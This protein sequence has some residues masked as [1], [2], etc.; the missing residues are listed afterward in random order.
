MNY[1]EMLKVVKEISIAA[2]ELILGVY[3]S[4][5]FEIQIKSDNSPVTKADQIANDYIVSELQKRYPEVGVLAEESQKDDVRLT[6]SHVWIIDPLDGTKEFIKRNGEFTVNVGLSENGVPKLGVVVIPVRREVYFAAAGTGA[7]FQDCEGNISEIQCSAISEFSE[8][9]L[10]K[11]RSHPSEKLA[12]LITECGFK[13]T[14]DSG[15]SI[16][17]CLIAHGE[18]EVYYRLG[19]TNEWDIC[20]AH[21]VLTEAGGELTDSLGAEIRYNKKDTLNKIGF[22]ASNATVHERL[23]AAARKYVVIS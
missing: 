9:T 15:S 5:D 19:P 20:A 13:A 14:K 17:I 6:Q 3:N 7:F 11:S 21:C 10:M 1:T 2:G 22:I 4:P 18:A 23:V 16:K 12:Q 8:M